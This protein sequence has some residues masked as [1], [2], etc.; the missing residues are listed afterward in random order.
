M[1]ELNF[2]QGVRKYKMNDTFFFFDPTDITFFGRFNKMQEDILDIMDEFDKRM[3]AAKRISKNDLPPDLI[4][5]NISISDVESI[6]DDQYKA[7]MDS[8]EESISIICDTD[9]KIKEALRITFHRN[10]DFDAIFD[11]GSIVSYDEDGNLVLQNFFDAVMPLI[12]KLAES[13]GREV[14]MHVGNRA[15]RRARNRRGEIQS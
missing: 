12:K 15:E 5:E 9:Q 8:S 10:N 6:S 14:N 2:K 1:D 11:N 7:I 13:S 4:K 3:Y